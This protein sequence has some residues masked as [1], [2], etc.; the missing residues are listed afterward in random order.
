M[1]LVPF[2]KALIKESVIFVVVIVIFAA[3]VFYLTIW[4]DELVQRKDAAGRAANQ[5]LTEKQGMD[6]KFTSVKANMGIYIESEAWIKRQ[7]L[8]IDSQ[9]VRD[10]FNYYQGPLFL[11]KMAVELQPIIDVT[12]PKFSQ[13]NFVTTKALA[14]VSLDALTDEDIYRLIRLMQKELPGFIKVTS[15]TMRKNGEITK[16][17]ISQVRREGAFAMITGEMNFEWYGLRSA[18]PESPIN[19][20]VPRKRESPGP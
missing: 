9:A 6:K 18:N 14:R 16:E 20:Y 1:N 4:R 5:M 10:L 2:R 15:L 19:R 11:K 7:G 12:D 13:K 3:A 8:F 17:V